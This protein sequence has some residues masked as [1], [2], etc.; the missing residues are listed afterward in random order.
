[1]SA[2]SAADKIAAKAAR[3]KAQAAKPADTPASPAPDD[4]PRARSHEVRSTVHTK[5]IRSTVDLAPARHAELKAWCGETAVMLGK[6]RV[7]TQDVFRAFV[8]RL[9]TDETL[10]RKIRSDLG[11]SD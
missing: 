5:P 2:Q 7:T 8:D 6:S 9:L 4:D 1:M 3:F 10:A 11:V